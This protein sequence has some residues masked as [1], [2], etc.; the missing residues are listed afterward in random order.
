MKSL[1][2]IRHA[3]SSWADSSLSD[4]DRPLNERGKHDAPRMAR[5]MRGQGAHPDALVS[6]T[7][8]RAR[9]TARYF[10]KEFG[11]AE[12]DIER[13]P[14]IYEAGTRALLQA[15]QELNDEWDTVFLFGHNPG[16]T[17]LANLFPGDYIDN[18]PTCGIVRLEAEVDSWKA[19]GP[20]SAV[21]R[22]FYYPKMLS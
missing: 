8:K 22:A 13:R 9:R 20:Q 3:K 21:Q 14:A 15:I 16:F 2:L 11:V 18:V 1:F 12:S 7:A 4:H 5:W 6:S 17:D 10:A 19:F